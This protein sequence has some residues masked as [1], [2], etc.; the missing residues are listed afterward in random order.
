MQFIVAY[1]LLS[2]IAAYYG[3]KTRLGLWG[4]LILSLIFTPIVTLIILFL[5]NSPAEK[6]TI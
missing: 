1:F 3:S 2:V 6:K 5:F 4:I